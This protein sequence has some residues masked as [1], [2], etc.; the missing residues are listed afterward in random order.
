MTAEQRQ[1]LARKSKGGELLGNDDV[2]FGKAKAMYF[3]VQLCKA[4]VKKSLA[5]RSL[6]K[7]KALCPKA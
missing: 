7:G 1:G 5:M 2:F 4:M 6:S 3:K